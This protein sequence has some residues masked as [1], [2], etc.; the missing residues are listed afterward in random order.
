MPTKQQSPV[1]MQY[2]LNIVFSFVA[3]GVILLL[4]GGGSPIW[5]Y[6]WLSLSLMS[7]LFVVTSQLILI[8]NENPKKGV[9]LMDLARALWDYAQF[10]APII[11]LF[12]L[13]SWYVG[14]YTKYQDVIEEG[15]LPTEYYNFHNAS[16]T[17]LVFEVISLYNMVTDM[18]NAKREDASPNKSPTKLSVLEMLQA[19]D[20]TIFYGFMLLS[21]IMAGFTH[22]ILAYFT[23]DG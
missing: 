11:L 6:S 13:T 16:I 2:N 14:Q 7:L 1:K 17:L 4:G 10:T 5:G 21:F 9:G 12:S 23:T 22:V 19:R 3:V 20:D 15:N 18:L 8:N